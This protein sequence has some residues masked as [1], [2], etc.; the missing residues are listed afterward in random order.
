MIKSIRQIIVRRIPYVLFNWRYMFPVQNSTLRL[1]RKVF[2]HAFPG[3]SR[4][5]WILVAL[6]N[7]TKWY[8][9]NGWIQLFKVWKRFSP[10]LFAEAGILRKK[11]FIDLLKL[12]FVQTTP[13]QFYYSYRLYRYPAIEWISFIYTNE[14]PNWHLIMSPMLS[15][16]SR[17]ILTDKAVFAQE[18]QKQG[19]PVIKGKDIHKGN[20]ISKEQL[21]QQSSLFLKPLCGSQQMGVLRLLYRTSSGVY[22]LII[23]EDEEINNCEQIHSF[24]QALIKE[25]DY[26]IQPLLKNH[27]DLQAFS[28]FETLITIRLVTIW[29]GSKAKAVSAVLELPKDAYSGYIYALPVDIG[30]GRIKTIMDFPV[31]YPEDMRQVSRRFAR[32]P[33]IY[34]NE[35]VDTALRA[36]ANFPDLFSIGWDLAVTPEGVKLI[37]G[38]IN[39]AV[40]PHQIAGPDLM[41]VF[42]KYA[43][44]N[45]A[46]K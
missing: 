18:M 4:I 17:N 37:E 33:V 45:L 11:Q 13:P 35:L 31:T 36:H 1:R 32:Q 22:S 12:V 46:F 21:F 15:K 25:Q 34:W 10:V 44:T 19:L 30:D 27:P 20:R 23:S 3:R 6:F 38:N 28:P 42:V 24:I 9:Y 41:P 39:W 29:T 7:Y 40:A 16:K 26:L 2:L 43:Q 8:L 14:L 5:I